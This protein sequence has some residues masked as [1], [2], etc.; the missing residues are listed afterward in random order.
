[1]SNVSSNVNLVNV[2]ANVDQW[3]DEPTL[4]TLTF[5]TKVGDGYHHHV[6]SHVNLV[7]VD[8]NVGSRGTLER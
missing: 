2:E 3:D 7:N 8:S 5:V 4:V 6:R 1:M